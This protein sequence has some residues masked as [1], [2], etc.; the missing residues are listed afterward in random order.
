M[1]KNIVSVS[2][3]KISP[4]NNNAKIHN[5]D[6]I[7]LIV[8]SIE[9]FGYIN[10]IVVDEDN[11]ILAGHGRYEALK[12]LGRKKIDVLQVTGLSDEQKRKY[13]LIDN[14]MSELSEWDIDLVKAELIDLNDVD[15]SDVFLDLVDISVDTFDSIS[16][17]TASSGFEDISKGVDPVDLSHSTGQTETRANTDIKG[18]DVKIET[19][20]RK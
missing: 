13:R 7:D 2:L 11:I 16:P 3:S 9:D 8:K 12:Q 15:F 1:D 4:Y 5:K 18:S 19:T 14:R 6:Q 10:Y 20:S 17:T